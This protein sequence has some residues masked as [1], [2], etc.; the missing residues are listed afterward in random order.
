MRHSQSFNLRNVHSEIAARTNKTLKSFLFVYFFRIS[1]VVVSCFVHI[2]HKYF[3]II[4]LSLLK[5]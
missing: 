4:R 2:K 1:T 3:K 5:C